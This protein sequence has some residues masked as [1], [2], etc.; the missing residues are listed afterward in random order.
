MNLVARLTS[1]K[2]IKLKGEV[3][4]KEVVVL[5]DPGA[6][7]NFISQAVVKQLE[8]PLNETKGYGVL[9]GTIVPVK[10]KGMCRGVQLWLQ[11]VK[12]VKDFRP[13]DLGGSDL[14]LGMQW[15]EN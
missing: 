2:T 12:I 11:R 13:L 14:I 6:T 7:H 10:G 8:I 1:P 9:L 3:C 5:I 15:L 4:G